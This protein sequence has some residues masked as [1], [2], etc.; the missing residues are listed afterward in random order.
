MTLLALI[1]KREPATLANANPA[2]PANDRP[3]TGGT[4]ARLATLALANPT[5][6]KPAHPAMIG[7]GDSSIASHWWL[8][9]FIDRDPLELAYY[10]AA[11]HA[12]ILE[13]HPDAVAAEPFIAPVRQP[14]APMTANEEMTIRA[15]MARIEETDPA[16]IA[17]VMSQCQQNA[18]ARGFFIGLAEDGGR[19][20]FRQ[21][22][23][24]GNK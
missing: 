20:F 12:E 23:D 2:N 9:H 11:T 6:E 17:E 4:L 19:G 24:D 13:R 18:D 22:G 8:I 3:P 21:G 15:W 7:A 10:P 14:S 1:R 16:T 5:N